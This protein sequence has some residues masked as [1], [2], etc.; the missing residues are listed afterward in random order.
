VAKLSWGQTLQARRYDSQFDMKSMIISLFLKALPEFKFRKQ[1]DAYDLSTAKE[2]ILLLSNIRNHLLR[3]QSTRAIYVAMAVKFFLR[4]KKEVQDI[5]TMPTDEDFLSYVRSNWPAFKSCL[6]FGDEDYLIWGSVIKGEAK[7]RN[8]I[9]IFSDLVMLVE[10]SVVS[11]VRRNW[12][13]S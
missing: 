7:M 6:D 13:E 12:S 3:S 8:E 1:K 9:N 11:T 10:L 4:S 5:C 2:F